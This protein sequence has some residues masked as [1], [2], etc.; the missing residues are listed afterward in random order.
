[1]GTDYLRRSVWAQFVWGSRISLFVG[2]AATVLTIAIGSFVGD[3]R[4][5]RRRPP[6]RRC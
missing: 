6:R 3:P 4:R 5:L 1:M 2:L